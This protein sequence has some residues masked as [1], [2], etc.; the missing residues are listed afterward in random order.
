MARRFLPNSKASVCLAIALLWGGLMAGQAQKQFGA[1]W[2]R[3]EAGGAER[4]LVL[5]EDGSQG[6]LRMGVFVG[7]RRVGAMEQHWIRQDGTLTVESRMNLALEALVSRASLPSRGKEFDDAL[8]VRVDSRSV[9][10]GW[11][12]ETLTVFAHIGG[13]PDAFASV[14]GRRVGEDLSLAIRRGASL[15]TAVFPLSENTGVDLACFPLV[16]LPRLKTGM[17][18]SVAALDLTTLHVAN[19]TARVVGRE[20]LPQQ[21]GRGAYVIRI[22]RG[23]RATTVWAA[24]D[25]QV[26]R[27]TLMGLTFVRE[28]AFERAAEFT[29]ASKEDRR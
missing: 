28:S 8:D 24:E 23:R 6:V 14:Q 12:L 10:E 20:D 7:D 11:Q 13:Q 4:T 1:F 17:A 15:E 21:N 2:C 29:V 26:L 16:A 22:G 9:L 19:D 27:K 3:Q 25:G 18:W 5:P